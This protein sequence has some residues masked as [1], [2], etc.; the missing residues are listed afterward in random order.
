MSVSGIYKII[1]KSNSKYYVGSSVNIYRRWQR[2]KSQLEKQCHN[3]KHLQSSWNKWSK[4]NFEWTIIEECP[5]EKLVETEQKYLNIAKNE[6]D[7]CYN[8]LFLSYSS[9]GF[10]YSEESKLRLSLSHRGKIMSE[11]SKQKSR[12]AHSG[13][14]NYCYNYTIFHLH[15]NKTNEIFDGTQHD[16][17]LKYGFRI[18]RVVRGMRKSCHGWKVKA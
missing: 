13:R 7:K 2:H 17:Y 14:N 4:N 3:N 6:Q 12:L 1:N 5:K 8:Q 16:F 15:N 11:E 9:L 10:K 18:I